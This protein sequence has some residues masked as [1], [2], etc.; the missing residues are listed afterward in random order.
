MFY[1][2][3]YRVSGTPLVTPP[4]GDSTLLA[5]T[6]SDWVSWCGPAA[7]LAQA[8]QLPKPVSVQ[9]VAFQN[10]TN[11]NI[12]LSTANAQTALAGCFV[13]G[14]NQLFD[15]DHTADRVVLVVSHQTTAIEA[16]PL[17]RRPNQCS[18]CT[19]QLTGAGR[20]LSV[21][22]APANPAQTL[23]FSF[24]DATAWQ[25]WKANNAALLDNGL[26]A[27]RIVP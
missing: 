10:E 14:Y 1:L 17:I 20:W 8:G 26:A 15:D 18:R 21:A 25:S 16:N 2:G 5:D 7:L 11:A 3:I 9:W 22:N 13:S 12:W 6:P 23:V 19:A 4:T 24:A 27:L